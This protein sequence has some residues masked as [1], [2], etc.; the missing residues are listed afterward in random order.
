MLIQQS[1]YAIYSFAYLLPLVYLVNW[2]KKSEFTLFVLLNG[3]LAIHPA[4]WWR[5][6]LVYINQWSD[7]GNALPLTLF[8]LECVLLFGMWW[9][10]KKV[11]QTL[12]TLDQ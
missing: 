8:F 10:M 1:S 7:L 5:T 11:F 6:G 2:E 9:F 3:V 4:I 12:N